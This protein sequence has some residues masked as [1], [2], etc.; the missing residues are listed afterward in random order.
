MPQIAIKYPTTAASLI[1]REKLESQVCDK[2]HSSFRADTM[3][4]KAE[5]ILGLKSKPLSHT[6]LDDDTNEY[7]LEKVTPVPLSDKFL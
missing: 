2:E 7:N 4:C 1:K 3:P 6:F 5:E